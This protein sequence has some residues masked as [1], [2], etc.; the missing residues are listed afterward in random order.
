VN[1]VFASLIIFNF[2]VSNSTL[3]M[4][5][6]A[7]VIKSTSGVRKFKK[8]QKSVIVA[9]TSLENEDLLV[10]QIEQGSNFITVEKTLGLS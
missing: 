10:H 6:K 7:K 8:P 4:T 5:K 1:K 2:F 9:S 3:T